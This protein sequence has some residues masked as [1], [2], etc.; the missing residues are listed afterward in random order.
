MDFKA[1]R[2][3][4]PIGVKC[5]AF[6]SHIQ[7]S[8]LREAE[9]TKSI[10]H[11]RSLPIPRS[12]SGQ[13]AR[14]LQ[15]DE[16]NLAQTA[17]LSKK[18]RTVRWDPRSLKKNIPAGMLRPCR[19]PWKQA[20]SLG[21]PPQSHSGSSLGQMALVTAIEIMQEHT[22]PRATASKSWCPWQ[23]GLQ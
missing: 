13:K 16:P 6:R 21:K 15:K 2:S 17:W 4:I 5:A 8:V 14:G 19:C 10:T 3:E 22:E 11:P 1:L 23:Q 9:V 7:G 18:V 12:L 20:Q